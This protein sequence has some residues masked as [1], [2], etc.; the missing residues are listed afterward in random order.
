M[1]TS[2]IHEMQTRLRNL[3]PADLVIVLVFLAGVA[4]AVY[5]LTLRQ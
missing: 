1:Q 2:P 4:V 5:T 3:S